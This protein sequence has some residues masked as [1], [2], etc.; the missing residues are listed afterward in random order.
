MKDSSVGPVGLLNPT[1]QRRLLEGLEDRFRSSVAEHQSLIERHAKES[2]SEETTLGSQRAVKTDAC[3]HMRRGMLLEWDEQEEKL[4][5]QYEAFAIKNRQELNRLGAVYRKKASVWKDAIERKV[6]ARCTAIHHQYNE[7]KD[8]PGIH[9]DKEIEQIDQSL[10]R[11]YGDVEWARALT[12]RRLDQLPEVPPPETP[13][14]N[15]RLPA[16]Q[17]VRE[18]LEAIDTLTR[19]CK[20]TVTQMQ[21]GAASKIVDSFYL[22]AGVGVFIVIWA[23]AVLMMKFDPPWIPMAAGVPIAGVIGF[24]IFL[25]LMMP[26]KRMTRQLHPVVER[27]AEAAEE[28][29]EAGR[30][31]AARTAKEA[32][33]E[34]LN[35]RDAHLETAARWRTEQLTLLEQTINTER[36]QAKQKLLAALSNANNEYK[37]AWNRVSETMLAKADSLA[38]RI[39]TDLADTEQT[40][41]Q[42]RLAAAERRDAERTRLVERLENGVERGLRRISE[43]TKRVRSRFPDWQAVVDGD[44]PSDATTDFI[45]VGQ[46]KVDRRLRHVLDASASQNGSPTPSHQ[47]SSVSAELVGNPVTGNPVSGNPMT[48]NTMTLADI[49]VPES[50]PVVLHRRLHC[51]LLISAKSADFGQAIDVAHQVLWRVLTGAAAGRAKLTL[52]D[53]VGRGQNFTSFMALTDHDPSLVGHRVWASE[54][55]ITERLGEIAQHVEDVLQSSLRD[56]FQRIEDYNE[57]AG[58]MAE[59]YR[60]IAAI[61]FPEGLT[62][63][64]YKHLQ[65]LLESGLRCGI[66]CVIV[67]DKSKPWPAETPLPKTDKLLRIDLND[68]GEWRVVQDG[69]DD[70]PFEP[71]PSPPMKLRPALV[72][73]VGKAA[74]AASRVEIPLADILKDSQAAGGSTADRI[75]IPI[76]SQGA[77]RH[78]PL[79]LGEGVRQHVL[80]AGKTGS[81]KSTLLHAIITSGA[82]RYTPDEL[83]YYLLDFKKGVEFKPYADAS[84]PHARVIGIES[85]REFG[86]SVLQRLDE[87][88]QQR[89]EKFR[90]AGVQELGEYR[91]KSGQ[92]MPR[93]MLVVDEFQELFVRDDRLAGDCAMLL[94]RL[95]RQG[96][97]FGMHVILSSQSLAGAYSLPRATLGQMA[98]RIAMQCSEADAAL[99]LADDNTAARLISRPGEAIYNDAGGLIEGNQPFQVAWLSNTAHGEM[100]QSI[101]TRDQG[102]VQSLP[103]AVVFEGNR[104]CRWTPLLANQVVSSPEDKSLYGL[105][106]EA[107][108]IGPPVAVKL[109]RDTGRNLLVMAPA[110]SRGAVIATC[111]ASFCKSDPR[112]EVIYFDGARVDDGESVGPWL[113]ESGIPSKIIKLR[114]VENEMVRVHGIV[115][116]RMKE[117]GDFPPIVLVLD[118]LERFRDL[119][120][121]ESFN[122]SLDAAASSL[123]GATALQECLR[124]GPAVNVFTIVISGSAETLSRW[125]PRA[126]QHDL[127]LRVLGRM[128]AS[129]SA[130]LIDTP[131]ASEL[132]AA[133][134]LLYDDTDGRICKFRQCDLPNA[135]DVKAWLT[136]S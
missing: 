28:A 27:I 73:Q 100:L 76:G 36:E 97:S 119:R 5:S 61:G 35:Q 15:Q 10:N 93:I 135:T 52:I 55:Q 59:P 16:P 114:D 34:L 39:S 13:E 125:L 8:K 29:A 17:D 88:L 30:K 80:I 68:D 43:S 82:Y 6:K 77:N 86:R 41:T 123:S 9:R 90:A 54:T 98:V 12:L 71:D 22:P 63:D 133:T 124:D 131:M 46:L 45:P 23:L 127:E 53:P 105:L 94:D 129:D 120:Q 85:E 4:T 99:I 104:P 65:A 25:L 132:S 107:V 112:T 113:G 91:K 66:F 51:G 33:V 24:T 136:P 58:S 81:G 47:S 126:S 37:T 56:R 1:R 110:D 111:V 79:D 26:L 106:G 62:R 78:L 40:L 18:A 116:E 117:E 32:E 134:M 96:R 92:T 101:A 2:E 42:Q 84:F 75:K 67:C 87:E 19:R 102:Y 11:I 49:S 118:P 69:L 60:V 20:Q 38:N 3:R 103:P 72:E 115:K 21:T 128:N 95:V 48:G 14:D 57:L 64:G 130:L 70:L 31:I 121:D 83:Q 7:R 109:T 89:G 44:C 108:E 50:M 122:F 74:L